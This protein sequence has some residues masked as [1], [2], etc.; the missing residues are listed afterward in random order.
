ME[1][2]IQ[3][4]G[5]INLLAL[6]AVGAAGYAV[7]VTGN[8]LA[9]LTSIA[10][11]GLGA[12]VAA[13]SW[14]QMR[15]EER[16]RLEKL[17]FEELTKSASSSALFT[18]G[19]T[20]ILPAQRSREQFERFFVPAFSVLLFLLQTGGALL[21]WRSL[22]KTLP[23]PPQQKVVALGLFAMFGLI[24]FLLGKFSTSL[25]RLK[26]LR[27]LRPG[28][29]YLLFGGYLCAAVALATVLV[30]AGFPQADIFFARILAGLL[31]LVGLETL[32]NL[33]LELYRPRVK[34]KVERPL[35]ESRL[36]SLLGQPE[37]LYTTAAQTL[38]YQFGFKVSETWAYR[39]FKQWL[40]VILGAQLAVLLLSTCVVFI[41]AGQ[42]AVLE[43]FG[44]PVA[45]RTVLEPGAHFKFPWPIEQVYRFPTEQIQTIDVGFVPDNSPTAGNTVLWTVSHTKEENFLVANR[46][47]I[48]VEKATN[49]TTTVNRAPPV[50]LLTVSIPVQFQITNLVSWLY[51]NEEPKELLTHIATREVVRFF[52]SVDL[53]EIM[54]SGRAGAATE[55]RQRIQAEADRHQLG[56]TIVFV[57]LQDIHPP[58]KVAPDYE[59]VVAAIH[60]KEANIL[61]AEAD[62]IRTNATAESQS[63]RIVSEAQSDRNRRVVDS[64]ARAALFTNQLPAY[65]ASPSVYMQR[66]YLQTFSR[67]VVNARK[68]ILLATNTQDIIILNLE[69]KIRKDLLDDLT[70]AP[71]TPAKPQ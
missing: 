14:F 57:G 47:L 4:N 28:A 19:E 49:G 17:D 13:V 20:E 41:D 54:S 36:V 21:I 62:A 32:I 2:N 52:V 67:S 31:L 10:F 29:T 15:L 3:R 44:S 33:I 66:A 42:Q 1:R 46:E 23:T 27:L 50:S 34:G 38:D 7:A 35:Y 40:L 51:N 60:T 9:G 56:A 16:E 61:A 69:D 53:H 58:V 25:T 5:L 12:L 26:N 59:K 64:M 63:F 55:L 68:Y 70:V 22:Q 37:G 45:G 18:A 8:S 30:L 65:M 71:K 24:L 43:R 11:L 48:L 6:L 39:L